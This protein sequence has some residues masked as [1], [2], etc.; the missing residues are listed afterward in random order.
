MQMVLRSAEYFSGLER[1]QIWINWLNQNLFFFFFSKKSDHEPRKKV[2]I[3]EVRKK[4]VKFFVVQFFL[5]TKTFLVCFGNFS[6]ELPSGLNSI[7]TKLVL[8]II[9]QFV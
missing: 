4:V 2:F 8:E 7:G 5:W 9:G 6:P 1:L 3:F